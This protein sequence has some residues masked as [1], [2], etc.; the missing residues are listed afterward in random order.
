VLSE[1]QAAARS[2]DGATEFFGGFNPFLNDDF[3]VG[4][5]FFVGA[6]LK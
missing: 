2:R 3:Y 4:E 1:G 6:A 5:T